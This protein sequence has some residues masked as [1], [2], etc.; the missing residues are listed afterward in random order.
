LQEGWGF[1]E[2]ARSLGMVLPWD[3]VD[4]EGGDED[5]DGDVVADVVT[6]GGEDAG[7]AEKMSMQGVVERPGGSS[8]GGDVPI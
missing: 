2:M 3:P 8:T 4:G 1:D 6:G 7:E 5:R